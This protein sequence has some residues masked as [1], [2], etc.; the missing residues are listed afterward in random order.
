LDLLARIKSDPKLKK[1]NKNIT[2]DY[3]F[4]AR[5]GPLRGFV[6][7]N[8]ASWWQAKKFLSNKNRCIGT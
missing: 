8:L 5:L 1:T 3:Y 2:G 7:K 6:G 4:A